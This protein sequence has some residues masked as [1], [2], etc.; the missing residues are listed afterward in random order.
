[1]SPSLDTLSG[2]MTSQIRVSPPGPFP[3]RE[4]IRIPPKDPRRNVTTPRMT[5]GTDHLHTGRPLP[6][7]Q[8]LRKNLNRFFQVPE[9]NIESI[10]SHLAMRIFD[11][12]ANILNYMYSSPFIVFSVW[13]RSSN[14]P[15]LNRS[16]YP[17]HRG[18]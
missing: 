10:G 3:N 14:C 1:M 15:N 9:T 13:K 16:C 2:Q 18:S 6:H 11:E 4:P 5:G 17:G 8:D 12:Y 7:E